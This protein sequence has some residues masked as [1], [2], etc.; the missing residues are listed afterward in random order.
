MP[1]IRNSTPSSSGC[2][3]DG[4]GSDSSAT[5]MVSDYEYPAIAMPGYA[6]KPLSKQ[7]E[8]IAVVGM[9]CRLPGDVSSPAQLWDLLMSKGTGRMDKVPKSRFNIDAHL[10]P[11]NERPGS[12]NVPGGYFLNSSLQEFD[13]VLF[14]IS[15][16]EA[17][18]MDPQQRKL[19]EVVYEAIESAGVSLSDIAGTTTACFVGSFTSDYQ[20]M[21]FKEP[22]FRHSYAATG[23]D[24]GIISNRINHVFNL[25]GP[26]ITVNTACSSSVYALHN[27]CN[28]LRNNECCA[29]IV[30]GTNLILTVDQHMNTAKLGVLSPTSTC[31]TFNAHADG[32][33]R[34]DG[35]GA[36]YLKTLKD[37]IRDGDPI[38]AVIR[39]SAVNSNGKAPGV[40][41]TH[42]NL[43]GQEAVIRHAYQRGG[44]L[45][46]MLTG[47]FEIHGTGT[48][49]GD[50]LEVYAVSKAM[51]DKRKPEDSP[52]L[53]GA[54]KTSIG[55]SEA[56]SGLSAVIKAVLSVEKGIIPPTRGFTAPNPAIDWKNWNVQVVTEPTPF[57]AHIPVKRIS[58]N[59]FGYGGTN[60][61]V[62]VEGT[63]SFLPYYQLSRRKIKNRGAF[64]RK[65]PY[66]L[67][68]SAHNRPTLNQN[69]EAYGKVIEKHNLLDLAY[70]L[71]NR[72]TRLS[73]RAYLVT[74]DASLGSDFQDITRSMVYAEKQNSPSVGFIFTGQGAQWVRMAGELI[75]YYPSFLR[76][77]RVLDRVLG[78]LPDTPE[79]TIEDELMASAQSSRV[80]EAEFSQPLCTAVQIALVDLLASWGIKPTVTIGHSS[81]EIAA[82][83]AAGKISKME[84]IVLA[85]YRGRA[86]RDIDTHGSMLAVGLGAYAVKPYL[87]ESGDN[88]TIACHNSPVSVT[89]SGDVEA[90]E[91]VKA[92][93][94]KESIFART[95]K[96][97][98]KAYHSRHMEQA[99]AKY[100]ELIQHAKRCL[101]F[102]RP[103]RSTAIMISSVTA[104]P[105][106]SDAH[107]DEY[108]WAANLVSPVL[109]S[110]AVEQLPSFSVDI[111]VEIGPHSALSGP[112]R[113]IKAEHNLDRLA[114]LPTLIRGQD[115][116][117]QLLKVAGE[118]FLRDYPLD[119]DRVTLIEQPL[120]NGKIDLQRGS[121][122]VDLPPYQWAYGSKNMFAEPRQSLEHRTPQHARHDVL[123]RRLPGASEMEPIWRN[124]LRIKDL[125]WLK[126]HSLGGDVVFPA[127]GYFSMAIEAITQ[128]N[129]TSSTPQEIDGY[130]LRDI[131]IKAALAIPEDDDGIETIFTMHP[132]AD[133][134]TRFQCT[135]WDFNVSSI[136]QDGTRK[137]HMAGTVS[138]N[139]RPRGQRPKK[140][141]DMPQK[142]SGKLWNQALRAVGFDYGP[143][144][145]DMD[146]IH[147]DGKTYAA[148]CNTVVKQ[149]SGIMQGESR[150][151]LHP[152]TVDSCL[153]LVIVSIYAGKARDVTCGAVPL[154]VDEV[155][156]WVPSSEQLQDSAATAYSWTDERGIRSFRSG[157]QLVA[158]DGSLLMDITDL[159]SVAYEAAVPQ[160]AL[161]GPVAQPYMEMIW[162]RDIDDVTSEDA[163]SRLSIA[164]LVEMVSH[165]NPNAKVL[166]MEGHNSNVVVQ[167]AS[168]FNYIVGSVSDG[169]QEK[170]TTDPESDTNSKTYEFNILDL[171]SIKEEKFDLILANG[172]DA[173][174]SVVDLVSGLLAP[175][176][177]AVFKRNDYLLNMTDRD[178]SISYI[179]MPN[180]LV[181][182]TLNRLA[183]R[184]LVNQHVPSFVFV[185]RQEPA[186]LVSQIAESFANQGWLT[187]SSPLSEVDVNAGER[188]VIVAEL[189]GPLLSTLE[190]AELAGIQRITSMTPSLLWVTQGGL[191][192]GRDPEYAMASGLARSVTSENASLD[193][194]TMDLDLKTTSSSS[195]V[196]AITDAVRRQVENVV[197]HETEYCVADG[198]AYISRLVPNKNLNSVYSVNKSKFEEVPYDDDRAV[199]GQ[200]QSGKVIF[201]DD[202]R[203]KEPLQPNQIE[204]KIVLSG[205]SKEGVLVIQG[206][207][208]PTTFSHEIFGTVTRVGSAVSRLVPGD[209]VAGF[210]F[211]KYASFQRASQELVGKLEA[212]ENPAGILGSLMAY[213]SAIHGL[214]DL[215]RLEPSENVLILDDIGP[216]GAAAIRLSQ[217]MGANTFVAVR[218][219][220]DAQRIVSTFDLPEARV[221]TGFNGTATQINATFGPGG[222]D[223]L[224]CAGS[225]SQSVVR[226]CWRHIAPFGRVVVCGRKNV[227]KRGVIDTVPLNHGASYFS[228][229]VL[230]LY[231]H[232]PA[233]LGR[234]LR[235]TL[236][237]YCQGSIQGVGSATVKHLT[238][239]DDAVAQFSDSLLHSRTLILHEKTDAF[240]KVVP[241]RPA[242]YFDPDATYLLVG[243]LGGLGRSLTSWMMEKGSRRFVF[244]S[245]SGTDSK[246]A[247]LLV[248]EMEAKGAIVQVVRGDVSLRQD[249]DRAV[250]VIK[251][252]HPI[253]GVVQAAA[254]FQDAMFDSL[255]YKQWIESIK[256]KVIG[257]LNLHEALKNVPLDFFI[258]T[259]STSG[260]LGTPGQANYAAANSFLDALAR[261]RVS[262]GQ[263]ASSLILPMVLGIGYVA[264][265]A[266]IEEGLKRKGIYG[267]DEEH[268][269][270]SFEA[271]VATGTNFRST[272]H[273]VIG[274][275]PAELQRSLNSAD[276][277][278]AFWLEDAR[279][280]HI[281]RTIQATEVESHA[282]KQSI[283]S[284][285]KAAGS[286]AEAIQVAAEHFTEKIIRL[287]HL[288]REEIEPHTKSIADYGLDSMI[289]VELRN[290]IFKEFG[291]D[292]PFQKLLAPSLTIMKFAAQ[293]CGSQA[294]G[295]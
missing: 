54:I 236:Q 243:C 207:D 134:E 114:Y 78:D 50:P 217:L 51:N 87:A 53:I 92:K 104:S 277:T 23:V 88:V 13:P 274:M 248:K 294:E 264:E 285:I 130:T 131:S 229:D 182:A 163:A 197:N 283:L 113:Q 193:F 133:D 128:M 255:T 232:R 18:W 103:S 70:T 150:H 115:C 198:V 101:P 79:W 127:A 187:R 31:H 14:G 44:D 76:A 183:G 137:D 77:I 121:M 201:E 69:I 43:E 8:P 192:S 179:V 95:L 161:D 238:K 91:D 176:G 142:A 288:D 47:Y 175:G 170:V 172:L 58:V 209:Q 39:S 245:R 181:I 279:F 22:D 231:Q 90:L 49:V 261:H 168:F 98:G 214:K 174:P 200:V 250:Q 147:Y 97:G 132:S 173:S 190:E 280:S 216:A 40:G 268:M 46:P 225:S 154:Q 269:L 106:A 213:A 118:L 64:S 32:Y 81:G 124:V 153:Q 85:F 165:K 164:D 138:I 171:E 267:I 37:A 244:L 135:W 270:Q 56:A 240:L 93:L 220:T 82:A 45:D 293:V 205:L 252:E 19:L 125:P 72:R 266:D 292:I 140:A 149:E 30:G 162:K 12:F 281:L 123:G 9:G 184:R 11:N 68:F 141:R 7:L 152:A 230:D 74:S 215:A 169:T 166:D 224:F 157:S 235:M 259:S 223:V 284:M 226:E 86:V 260:T 41:I 136:S 180:D 219:E 111:L 282:S 25:K 116:A 62:I 159:R 42:P 206:Q 194:V 24:P 257:T 212:N 196:R 195:A 167:Q 28:A 211:D 263:P 100:V 251:S 59:S 145:Q 160:R 71:G 148:S 191:L 129:E 16:V 73:S 227:L 256:P 237:L 178:T 234:A 271:G 75:K 1:L 119:M 63:D 4:Y 52:L 65:R 290:W 246:Q 6:E 272:D 5:S 247:A 139:T 112:I 151:V 57:P 143:T 15:P 156:I 89:L 189:E 110:Q 10:H 36:L 60:G 158:R 33:G 199:V 96:T 210:N 155:A 202:K 254:N 105:I 221:V 273:I 61:H 286:E 144:F 83:Y 17:M 27:A 48:P 26:S 276:T 109:F 126:D 241:T 203:Y 291:L 278:D 67:V 185:Y 146:Q 21:T 275:D 99:S 120:P 102:D 107:I 188:M 222:I 2:S 66:L 287:L 239:L 289:G 122:L 295:G 242:A 84:A 249:V 108:Y 29:A 35:V 208:Y 94:E 218:T 253:K 20:Q 55:H 38:R 228:F 204:I 233:V 177:R 262:N 117:V 3:L 80:N 34:A 186:P 258:M 265:N